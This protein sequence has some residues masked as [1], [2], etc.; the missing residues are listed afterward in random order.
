MNALHMNSTNVFNFSGSIHHIEDF[1]VIFIHNLNVNKEPDEM[2]QTSQ[3]KCIKWLMAL[4]NSKH[5]LE[6]FS[7]NSLLTV[8]KNGLLSCCS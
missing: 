5:I 3:I 6:K 8:D 2:L 1:S 4:L 7:D